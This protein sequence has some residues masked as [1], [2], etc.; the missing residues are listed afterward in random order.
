MRIYRLGEII[1]YYTD[2]LDKTSGDLHA[3]EKK[4]IIFWSEVLRALLNDSPLE[5]SVRKAYIQARDALRSAE[6]KQRQVGLH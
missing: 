4:R 6:E 5:E 1:W 2:T 3:L